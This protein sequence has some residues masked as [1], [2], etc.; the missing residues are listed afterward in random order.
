VLLPID[1]PGNEPVEPMPLETLAGIVA[2]SG[3]AFDADGTDFD[4]LLTAVQTAGLAGALDDPAADLTVFAPNDAAFVGFAQTLG[5]EG[6]DEG[7][8]FGYIVEA[9]TLL[10]GGD[11]I[12]LLTAVLTYHISPG[13][14]DATAVLGSSTIETLQGAT[15]GVDGT[16][17]VDADPDIAD[18]SIIATDLAA[19]NGIAHV[20]DGVLLPTDL[21]QSDG[22]NDVDFIIDGEEGT[23]IATGQDND[24]VDGNGG[25]D[26]IFLGKGEDVGVGGAGNDYINGGFGDDTITGGTGDDRLFGA[27]GDD[28]FVFASGDGHDRITGFE[29][30][31]D[32]IDLTSFG[33][34]GFEELESHIVERSNGRLPGRFAWGGS[35]ICRPCQGSR[36]AE[37]AP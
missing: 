34:T 30:G 1:I 12:P 36:S 28:T 21:L 5:F 22:S 27:Q 32:K 24:L 6:S 23:R 8:A 20:I 15:L 25:N 35:P 14:K 18:P 7:E 2:A 26:R 4:L 9:L 37:P 10:G 19:S 29:K 11:P 33:F 31:Q 3:G 13:A 17:L 16:T